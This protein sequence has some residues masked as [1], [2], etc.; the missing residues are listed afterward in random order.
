[1]SR[2]WWWGSELGAVGSHYQLRAAR[3][4]PGQGEMCPDVMNRQLLIQKLFRDPGL[5]L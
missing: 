3:G 4:G 1:M 2:D 5:A